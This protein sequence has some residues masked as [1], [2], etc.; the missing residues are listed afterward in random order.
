MPDFGTD[1]GRV[2]WEFG[3]GGSEA[4]LADIQHA[5]WRDINFAGGTVGVT[6]TFG[7]VDAFGFTDID[8]N[9]KLDVAFREIYS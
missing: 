3:L 2:A 6:F 7:F 8:D 1:I 4:I 5:G 9:G